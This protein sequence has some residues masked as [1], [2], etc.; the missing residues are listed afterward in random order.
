MRLSDYRLK[1]AELIG[2][3]TTDPFYKKTNHITDLAKP[4]AA[5]IKKRPNFLNIAS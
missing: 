4:F 3:W 2:P 5:W 1:F